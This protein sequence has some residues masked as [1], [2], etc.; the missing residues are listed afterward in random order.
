[1]TGE[2]RLFISKVIILPRPFPP[3]RSLDSMDARESI[4]VAASRGCANPNETSAEVPTD[5]SLGDSI[6]FPN[7]EALARSQKSFVSRAIITEIVDMV[8]YALEDRATLKVDTYIFVHRSLVNPA[9]IDLLDYR[10]RII[11]DPSTGT[12]QG[13]Q[14]FDFFLD[15]FA[16]KNNGFYRPPVMRKASRDRTLKRKEK[17]ASPMQAPSASQHEPMSTSPPQEDGRM[18]NSPPDGSRV[19]HHPLTES[20]IS[21]ILPKVGST[22]ANACVPFDL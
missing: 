15:E 9:Y 2:V 21:S 19:N 16:E 11:D 14:L 4:Y 7:W 20:L 3:T 13:E 6:T 10:G 22:S 5:G 18:K 17:E 8:I 1:M 12:P